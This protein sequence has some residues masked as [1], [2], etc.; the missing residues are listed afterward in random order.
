MGVFYNP[1]S[2]DIYLV[3]T[4]TGMSLYGRSLENLSSDIMRAFYLFFYNSLN[5]LF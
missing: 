2:R 4:Y 1:N 3:P 5:F